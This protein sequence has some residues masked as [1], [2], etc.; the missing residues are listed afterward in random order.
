MVKFDAF[1]TEGNCKCVNYEEDIEGL[2]AVQFP[3]LSL[4]STLEAEFQAVYG[5]GKVFNSIKRRSGGDN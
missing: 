2:R 1:I 4:S 3:S 5:D